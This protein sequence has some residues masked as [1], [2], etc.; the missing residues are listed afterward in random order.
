MPN[1]RH[2]D[3]AMRRH[4]IDF[5]F[6]FIASG[7]PAILKNDTPTFDG[8]CCIQFSWKRVAVTLISLYL[9]PP[10]PGIEKICKWCHL[11]NI[12]DKLHFIGEFDVHAIERG[13]LYEIVHK[14]AQTSLLKQ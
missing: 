6:H 11:Q 4:S 1:I 9:K 5:Y 3:E 13:H 12:D 2:I 8:V 7:E 14:Y 10:I